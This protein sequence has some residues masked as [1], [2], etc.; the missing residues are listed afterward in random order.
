MGMAK[1]ANGVD[2]DNGQECPNNAVLSGVPIARIKRPIF[3]C[4]AKQIRP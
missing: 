3:M 2:S 4:L 1:V